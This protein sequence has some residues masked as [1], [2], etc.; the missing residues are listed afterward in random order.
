MDIEQ[1]LIN[2][3]SK[4]QTDKIIKFIGGNKVRFKKLLDI[5]FKGEYRITQRAAWPLSYVA[6]NYPL[7]IQPHFFKLIKKLT[8][9]GNHPAIT[10][11]I[12]R[13]FEDIEIPEK[14]HGILIN[15]CFKFI[16]DIKYPVAIRAFA[17]TVSAKICKNYPDIKREFIL[18]L[19]ELKK[20]PQ[21]PAISVR[22]RN[23][24]ELL[25]VNGC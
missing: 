3:H 7:L 5:F 4:A 1:A 12:L 22:I 23:A 24:F 11:N 2:E 6:I 19:D 10:R 20:H 14:Y 21:Q 18:I 17:I 15:L 13:I 8:E 9:T 16:V 25:S